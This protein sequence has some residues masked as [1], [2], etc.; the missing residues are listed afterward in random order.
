MNK[1]I[2]KLGTYS[3]ACISQGSYNVPDSWELFHP[4]RAPTHL[5][6]VAFPRQGHEAGL[7]G[8]L[9]DV[10]EGGVPGASLCFPI[11]GRGHTHRHCCRSGRRGSR[12]R[13]GAGVSVDSARQ[14]A[15]ERLQR[16]AVPR[17]HVPVAPSVWGGSRLS[18]GRWDSGGVRAAVG[19]LPAAAGQSVTKLPGGHPSVAISGL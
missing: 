12:R 9:R 15:V 16:V 2:L 19:P 8:R 7:P 3:P 4:S 5:L 6:P 14:C 11:G 17:G 13:S 10:T 18:A 1:H